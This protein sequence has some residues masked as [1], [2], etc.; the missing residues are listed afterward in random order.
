[1]GFR[2]INDVMERGL[3]LFGVA[4]PAWL[5]SSCL[6]PLKG[7][8][9]WPSLPIPFS[10]SLRWRERASPGGLWLAGSGPVPTSQPIIVAQRTLVRQPGFCARSCDPG[11]SNLSQCEGTEWDYNEI[12]VS[13]PRGQD[14]DQINLSTTWNTLHFST[15]TLLSCPPV[16]L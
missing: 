14:A 13:T 15:G 6:W 11:E 2:P 5:T 10:L 1:M 12:E 9:F 7:A 4:R 8:G 3:F 16:P